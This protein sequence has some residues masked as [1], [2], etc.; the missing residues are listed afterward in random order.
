MFKKVA[1]ENGKKVIEL[2]NKTGHF[3]VGEGSLVEVK[4]ILK[5]KGF[6]VKINP[7]DLY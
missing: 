5:S 6:K 2:S 4:A 1:I 3:R 7:D